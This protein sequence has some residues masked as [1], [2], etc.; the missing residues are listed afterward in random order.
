MNLWLYFP[1]ILFPV[2]LLFNFIGIFL[3]FY[4]SQCLLIALGLSLCSSFFS[5]AT[6]H[7]HRP[8]SLHAQT[9]GQC[10]LPSSPLC[11]C[12]NLCVLFVL[13]LILLVTAGKQDWESYFVGVAEAPGRS[14]SCLLHTVR[15]KAHLSSSSFVHEIE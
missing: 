2:C 10:S 9:V 13:R 7:P 6:V 15:G 14:V 11:S 5:A 3:C 1:Q 4:K 12:S 8:P